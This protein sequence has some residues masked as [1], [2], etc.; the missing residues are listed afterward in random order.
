[1]SVFTKNVVDLLFYR[2]KR[3]CSGRQRSSLICYKFSTTKKG[4][5]LYPQTISTLRVLSKP[6]ANQEIIKPFCKGYFPSNIMC[7]WIISI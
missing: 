4:W 1:M 5:R 3:S 7:A 2:P 6:G